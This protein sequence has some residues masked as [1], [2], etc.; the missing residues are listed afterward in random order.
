MAELATPSAAAINTASADKTAPDGK[1]KAAAVS[2][3]ERPDDEA[4]KAELGKAEKELKVAEERMVGAP[5]SSAAC[6][7]WHWETT[8]SRIG[9]QWAC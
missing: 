9:G 8:A 6:I 4:Y 5:F 2:K 3:P 1:D 7:A